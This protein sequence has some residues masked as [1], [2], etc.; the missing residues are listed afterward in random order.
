MSPRC[1]ACLT[2]ELS[3]AMLH[4][5]YRPSWPSCGCSL[6]W[7]IVSEWYKH[8]I[9][10]LV[11]RLLKSFI[12]QNT[13]HIATLC[14]NTSI[15]NKTQIPI[16]QNIPQ[17]PPRQQLYA[18]TTRS[19]S[20]TK[21]SREGFAALSPR[22]VIFTAINVTIGDRPTMKPSLLMNLRS[23]GCIT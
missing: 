7:I 4:T 8:G 3:D 12:R 6:K 19:G 23:E 17:W 13:K 14:S 15:L 18:K 20:A 9:F 5:F 10:L 22:W 1:H 11:K 21:T 2:C 16:S